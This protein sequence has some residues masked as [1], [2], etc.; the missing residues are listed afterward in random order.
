MKGVEPEYTKK[1]RLAG[2]KVQNHLEDLVQDVEE[3]CEE[4][5]ETTEATEEDDSAASDKLNKLFGGK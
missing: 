5:S 2:E 1:S 4:T 3:K